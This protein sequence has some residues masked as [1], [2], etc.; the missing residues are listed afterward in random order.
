M[1]RVAAGLYQKNGRQQKTEIYS[2]LKS[3]RRSGAG[4]MTQLAC[5][6][7]DAYTVE[8]LGATVSKACSSID[9][10]KTN[11]VPPILYNYMPASQP[12][13]AVAAGLAFA[14]KAE[15]AAEP[16]LAGTC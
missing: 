9:G 11:I 2:A 5:L 6:I 3:W 7:V 4:W 13:I 1:D 10:V 15:H 8:W 12:E 14:K 16:S